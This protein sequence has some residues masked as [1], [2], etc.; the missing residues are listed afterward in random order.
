M[1]KL[2]DSRSN[3]SVGYGCCVL[4]KDR[5]VHSGSKQIICKRNLAKLLNVIAANEQGEG[6]GT[7]F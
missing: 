5:R 6:A 4:G 3:A 1:A 7:G 2:Y